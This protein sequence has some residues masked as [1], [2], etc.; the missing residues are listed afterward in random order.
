MEPQP[1]VEEQQQP[2]MEPQPAV[3]EQQQPTMEPQPAVEEQPQ[4]NSSG[5]D[6]ENASKIDE[7]QSENQLSNNLTNTDQKEKKHDMIGEEDE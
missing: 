1:A 6:P 4:Q 3:E 2:T 7:E 5:A